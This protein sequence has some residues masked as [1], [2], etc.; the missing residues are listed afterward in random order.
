[1]TTTSLPNSVLFKFGT[2]P[3]KVVPRVPPK[4][5]AVTAQLRNPDIQL[6]PPT[7]A[8]QFASNKIPLA[9]ADAGIEVTVLK[10]PAIEAGQRIYITW[11]GNSSINVV[12]TV[13][14][15]YPVTIDDVDNPDFSWTVTVPPSYTADEGTHVLS[16]RVT[17]SLGGNPTWPEA[18]NTVIIDRTAPGGEVLPILLNADGTQIVRQL[19]SGDLVNDEFVT[20][21]ADYD[22]M[23]VNDVIVPWIRG[24][25]DNIPTSFPGSAETV[26][27]DE[28]HTGNVLLRFKKDDIESVGDGLNGFGYRV[29]DEPGNESVLSPEARI[30][31]IMLDVP[32]QLEQPVVPAYLDG[33]GD[34]DGVVSYSDAVVGVDVQIPTYSTPQEGDLVV[35]KWGAQSSSSYPLQAGDIGE[36]P[37]TTVTM[38][39]AAV[40]QEGSDPRLPV[41]YTIER[42]GVT[43]PSP[44]LLVNV[45]LSVPGGPDPEANLQPVVILSNS[46]AVDRIPEQDFGLDAFAIINH[47]TNNTPP[48]FAFVAGDQI[49]IT[50]GG[51][52]V[53]PP[54]TVATGDNAQPLRLP[55]SGS[56][57]DTSGN[58]PVNYRIRRELLP[59]YTPPIYEEGSPVVKLIPVES[60]QGKPNDGQPFDGPTF[61]D[62]VDGI[63]DR[64]IG[65]NGARVR[66]IVDLPGMSAQNSVELTVQG[67]YYDSRQ[68]IPGADLT[69]PHTIS[70]EELTLGYYDFIVPRTFLLQICQGW[71]V[72][73]YK[74]T[75]DI[76]EGQ[77]DPS[78]VIVDMSNTQFPFC[79]A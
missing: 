31:V 20:L 64:D 75:N 25:R 47:R 19:T 55:F 57:I 59:P 39:F 12:P 38:L 49:I 74:L 56:Y 33:S 76:G 27:E 65:T 15:Y 23:E 78:E 68:P 8:G 71:M 73:T 32:T 24:E 50:W 62:A 79:Q 48:T 18:G 60:D 28:V 51:V 1:M 7:V 26:D 5:R 37:V 58:I 46:L 4:A 63:I 30:R 41:S 44:E 34:G 22:G 16:F 67:L 43:Y 21:V 42:S 69:L 72:T 54:Y 77:S 10:W 40:I 45:D 29:T 70:Q 6:L 61:P 53:A 11:D 3:S 35:V 2:E 14:L 13:P 36:D 52:D 9:A 17:S 66:C